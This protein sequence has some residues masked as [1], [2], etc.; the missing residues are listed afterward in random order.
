MARW[1]VGK[2]L[3]DDG[4]QLRL[5]AFS[6]GEASAHRANIDILAKRAKVLPFLLPCF[7]HSNLGW[8]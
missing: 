3:N 8:P 6:N 1:K 2:G 5:C 4:P 7:R